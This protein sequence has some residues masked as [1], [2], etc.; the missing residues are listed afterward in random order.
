[1]MTYSVLGCFRE[2]YHP[3]SIMR[4]DRSILM[5]QL[6]S[7]S[8]STKSPDV[9]AV[10]V[11]NA[12]LSTLFHIV[13]WFFGH[14]ET[15]ISTFWMHWSLIFH[16]LARKAATSPSP[17]EVSPGRVVGFSEGRSPQA[18]RGSRCQS[19]GGSV[20][21]SYSIR[22]YIYIY[23]YIYIYI[24]SCLTYLYGY[25]CFSPQSYWKLWHGAGAVGFSS[26]SGQHSCHSCAQSKSSAESRGNPVMSQGHRKN[27]DGKWP[28]NLSGSLSWWNLSPSLITYSCY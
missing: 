27:L 4:W 6:S 28:T 25:L 21:I 9:E 12:V 22:L 2:I 20:C 3:S 26:A 17:D 23:S 7:I 13:S 24:R 10:K 14:L 18:F 11:P 19:S 15:E 1:M 8:R 16:V 5:A